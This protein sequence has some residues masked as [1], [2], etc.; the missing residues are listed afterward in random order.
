MAD[1][2]RTRRA[3]G[4]LR[5]DRP[6]IVA[7][8]LELAA[9][10]GTAT[11]SFRELGAHLGV[12]PT[13]MYRHFRNK[14]ELT[15]ALLEELTER[16]LA[17]VTADPD[18]WQERLR[19][20]AQ[21]ALAEFES[22]PASGIEAIALTTHGAAER[23]AIELMLDAFSRAGLSG[24][25]LVRHYALLAVHVLAGASNMARARIERGAPT[26][27]ADTWLDRPILA[28]PREFPHV[29]ALS[30]ELAAISDA[31]L[32]SAGVEMVIESAVRTAARA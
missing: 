28:D 12:D 18:D 14:D 10:P 1:D 7:A 5:L 15:K 30:V 8:A 17:H 31:D 6:T 13:A 20:L 3:S 21:G 4:R 27:R 29:A 26:G 16:G 32:F 23:R 22:Y 9:M 11:I 25:D 24:E 19:Q 2:A